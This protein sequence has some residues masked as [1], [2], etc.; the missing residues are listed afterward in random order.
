MPR[1][2]CTVQRAHAT[3]H[4]HLR[5]CAAQDLSAGG[6]VEKITE[7]MLA[8]GIEGPATQRDYTDFL[9]GYNAVVPELNPAQG[10]SSSASLVA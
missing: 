4:L 7:V 6:W 3:C 9:S 2:T 1:A 10:G 8:A 5:C